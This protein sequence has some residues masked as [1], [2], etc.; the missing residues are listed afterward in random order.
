MRLSFLLF[1]ALLGGS[2]SFTPSFAASDKT[3]KIEGKEEL[4]TPTK[5]KLKWPYRT[6][7]TLRSHLEDEPKRGDKSDV[8]TYETEHFIFH[9]P[10]MLNKKARERIARFFECGLTANLL[11]TNL[12]PIRR[13][14]MILLDEEKA[15]VADTE[16]PKRK[17]LK[18]V[19]YKTH[20]EYVAA[21]FNEKSAGI[22]RYSFSHKKDESGL[23]H[24]SVH[25]PLSSM[26]IDEKGR[27]SKRDVDPAVLIHEITHQCTVLNHFPIWA[28]EGLSEYVSAMPYKSYVLN[29]ANSDKGI[30]KRARAFAP[31]KYP[32]TLEQFFDISQKKFTSY[33]GENVNTYLLSCMVTTYFLHMTG[34]DGQ[35]RYIKYLDEM[36]KG[37]DFKKAQELLCE[38]GETLEDLQKDFVKKW[39]RRKVK[40]SF[41]D[42]D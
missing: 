11:L 30:E 40:V 16:A 28:N 27:L 7:V 23:G 10:V 18:A 6:T 37:M 42:E 20:E 15:A 39:K 12:L 8:L 5:K 2:L 3:P 38:E 24:D 32:F 22:Y 31:L 17:K 26:G 4:K 41:S 25:V 34:K 1:T 36:N 29:F 9:S 33:M 35:Q 19:F 14:E 21:G 13:M